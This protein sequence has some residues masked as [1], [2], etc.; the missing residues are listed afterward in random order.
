MR[1]EP[2]C[3]PVLLSSAE[4]P[5]APFTWVLE[6]TPP[7]DA[8]EP[9]RYLSTADES[10]LRADVSLVA[11]RFESTKKYCPPGCRFQKRSSIV[12]LAS[13]LDS[14]YPSLRLLTDHPLGGVKATSGGA[15]AALCGEPWGCVV[16][17]V[18]EA[19]GD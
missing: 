16:G 17:C 18:S 9:Y 8:F 4:A 14:K 11:C 6:A 3:V 13:A 15:G 1:Y 2:P 5:H 19:P 10:S 7:A 12:P